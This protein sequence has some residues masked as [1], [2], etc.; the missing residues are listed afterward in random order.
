MLHRYIQ[1]AVGLISPSAF[2]LQLTL[3]NMW[4]ENLPVPLLVLRMFDTVY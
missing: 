2:V 3:R 1:K 4:R